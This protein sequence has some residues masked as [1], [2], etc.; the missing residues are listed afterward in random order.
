MYHW[1]L[2]LLYSRTPR[3]KP[4]LRA[5]FAHNCFYDQA[6]FLLQAGY[7][8]AAV[9]ARLAIEKQL[10]R[11]AL[12]STD[13]QKYRCKTLSGRIIFLYSVGTIDL[14]AKRRLC[15][16]SNQV[17]KFVPSN[18]NLKTYRR[19]GCCRGRSHADCD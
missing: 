3:F 17:N 19:E 16:W 7:Y 2:R 18:G 6:S 11:L 14:G 10:Q 8:N 15:K 9:M 12:I 1:W 4:L 5:E 13:W